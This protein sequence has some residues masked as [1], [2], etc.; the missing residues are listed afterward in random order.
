[1]GVRY[2]Y[3]GNRE[4]P[5]YLSLITDAYSKKII[6]FDVSDSLATSCLNENG[7][8][9]EN[10]KNLIHHSDRGLQYCPMIIKSY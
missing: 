4:N 5:T 2:Y 3:L 8:E 10:P 1:M 9:K 7:I 6:G